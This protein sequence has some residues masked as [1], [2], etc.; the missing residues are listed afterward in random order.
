MATSTSDCK[1]SEPCG[2]LIQSSFN[3]H[4]IHSK[5][6]KSAKERSFFLMTGLHA[7]ETLWRGPGASRPS[8]LSTNSAP[9][10]FNPLSE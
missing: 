2:F 10:M 5:V 6:A 9:E 1:R 3:T 7:T 4:L 8:W